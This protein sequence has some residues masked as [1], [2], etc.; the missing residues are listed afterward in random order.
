MANPY[1]WNTDRL[2]AEAR[3]WLRLRYPNKNVALHDKFVAVLRR[4][5]FN[6]RTFIQTPES[7]FMAYAGFDYDHEQMN[8]YKLMYKAFR[9]LSRVMIIVSKKTGETTKVS[10]FEVFTEVAVE[11]Q[12]ME[13]ECKIHLTDSDAASIKAIELLIC[14]MGNTQLPHEFYLLPIDEVWRVLTLVNIKAPD[15]SRQGKYNVPYSVLSDWF[16]EW[17]RL[18]QSRFTKRQQYELL[19]FPTFVFG[20]KYFRPATKWLVWNVVGQQQDRNPLMEDENLSRTY[21]DMCLPGNLLREI[22]DSQAALKNRIL[23]LLD[24]FPERFMEAPRPRRIQCWM[25]FGDSELE[26]V[27]DILMSYSVNETLDAIRI[28]FGPIFQRDFDHCVTCRTIINIRNQFFNGVC[29]SCMHQEKEKEENW[30]AKDGYSKSKKYKWMG[31]TMRKSCACKYTRGFNK[32]F[33]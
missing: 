19:L 2:V 30:E 17:F 15:Y 22:E 12:I 26:P 9:K 18:N 10:S 21:M 31:K 27:K 13:D 4:C 1:F 16:H 29:L 3:T 6:G 28:I 11:L 25:H 5:G 7:M 23:K 20:A 8:D 14:C 24:E 33:D 32:P